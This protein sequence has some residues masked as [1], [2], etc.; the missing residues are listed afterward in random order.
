METKLAAINPGEDLARFGLYAEPTRTGRQLGF[1]CTP[2][3]LLPDECPVDLLKQWEAD[4]M[5][6]HYRFVFRARATQAI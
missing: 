1:S 6:Q 2:K 3:I 4:G 5:G